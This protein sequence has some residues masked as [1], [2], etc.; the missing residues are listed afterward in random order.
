MIV[1][2]SVLTVLASLC[3]LAG[4]LSL[5]GAS[6]LALN[7]RA[8]VSSFPAPSAPTGV[9][10][11]QETGNVFVV[12]SAV[13]A[14]AA[15]GPEG[16]AP[17]GVPATTS[18]FITPTSEPIGVAVDNACWYHQPRLTGA[19][20]ETFDPSN[21]DLY[22]A[23]P[24]G[25]AIEKLSLNRLT[26]EY[27]VAGSFAFKEPNGVAVDH[28]GNV[29]VADY[30]ET[31]IPVFNTSG[32]EIGKIETQASA[33]PLI[34]HP[35]FI[36]AGS[37]GDV[38][39]S[40]YEGGTAQFT[41]NSKYEVQAERSLLPS[42]EA[43]TLDGSEDAL[44]DSGSSVAEYSSSGGLIGRFGETEPEALTES[45]GLAVNVTTGATFVSLRS[46]SI[47]N[48]YGATFKRPEP[49]TGPP[50]EL[51]PTSVTL[52]GTV[53]P[54]GMPVTSCLFEY[55]T[56]TSYEHTAP[57]ERSPGGEMT[58][59]VSAKITGLQPNTSYHYRAVASDKNGAIYGADEQFV[60]SGPPESLAESVSDVSVD[61]ATFKGIID[62]HKLPT[63]YYFQYGTSTGYGTDV[64]ALPGA[65]VG[66]GEDG[67]EV[68]QHVQGLEAGTVYHY[69]VVAHS[70]LG[71]VEGP[72]HTFTTQALESGSVVLD[73]REWELVSPPDKDGAL[74][75]SVTEET[76]IQASPDGQ[77]LT[78]VANS[79]TEPQPEGNAQLAQIFSTRGADGWS[80]R[81]ISIPNDEATGASVGGGGAY[82]FFSEDLGLALVS[83]FGSFPA[84]SSAASLSPEASAQTL[85]RRTDY[86]SK[87]VNST[88]LPASMHC[89]SPLVTGA[90]GFSDVPPGTVFS[91]LGATKEGGLN[92]LDASP[93]LDHVIFESSVPLT[94]TSPPASK[95]G[96][97]EWSAGKSRSEELQLV[98]VLSS[99]EPAI[100]PTLGSRASQRG[101][102]SDDG[103]RIIWGAQ[104]GFVPGL[105][106]RYTINGRGKTVQ[107]DDVQ[108]GPGDHQTAP[109]FQLAT[110]DGSKVFF[111]DTQ[112]LTSDSGGE[113]EDLY[114][115]EMVE[116]AGELTCKLTDLT[117]AGAGGES[118]AVQDAVIGSSTDGSS[119]YFVALGMLTGTEE[120]AHGERAQSEQPNLYVDRDGVIKLVAVLSAQ[121]RASWG[122]QVGGRLEKLTARVSPDGRWLAFMSQR[123]LT[124]Y[125]NHDVN[126]GKPDEEVYLYDAV[127]RQLVC[128]SCDPTG[129][130]PAGIESGQLSKG[131][132][133]RGAAPFEDSTWIAA[134][135]PGWTSYRLGD[136]LYQ[137]RYLSDSGRLFFNSDDALVPKDVDATEDV[138]EYEPAG[139]G[140]CNAASQTFEVGSDGCVG[141]ISSGESGEESAFLDASEDGGHV[142][143][144]T[145]SKLAGEDI[146]GALDVYDA[147]E[148]S[149]ASPCF[150]RPVALP[151]P[152]D[153]GDACKT[154][155][156]PQ[157]A[158]FGAPASSTFNG[159]GNLTSASPGRVVKGKALTRKQKLARALKV[160]VKQSKRKRA[161]CR[162][163]AKRVYGTVSNAK[164]T[165]KGGK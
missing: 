73:G 105:F 134:N 94:E 65:F 40:N 1:R 20:C 111:T 121:D 139:V 26:E 157:P 122:Y 135:V 61:S 35:A 140:D 80:T 19:A 22:V 125:D 95:G 33:H 25:N 100:N 36:A 131:G 8:F 47:V 110:P 13:G 6:A 130:R 159:A 96:L 74:L 75:E 4:G 66:S 3:V 30:F 147:H 165:H 90:E 162:R 151:P 114:E 143:F 34:A 9:A 118:A 108:G 89:Y 126:S 156:T 11:D 52:N 128:G 158:I 109:L 38:Y 45:R 88:C 71:T 37:F 43:V 39:V 107:L 86:L 51:R 104:P 12:E 32:A 150:A 62:P 14:I 142:F 63:T 27:E 153:T 78:Y 17:L 116:V 64:P 124:G 83:P 145:T 161:Q 99:N 102:I 113:G 2:R 21:G 67:V 155:P 164:K 141:L 148:C 149:P 42:G 137:S 129:A 87:E 44:V 24:I 132:L 84:P 57:C 97:Y 58:V 93:D 133:V 119:V 60:T 81:D 160:C 136:A 18:G 56:T 79:P 31:S 76:L 48:I 152:C 92:F 144:L 115:C 16:G 10:V 101:A 5:C 72:D 138:Y 53:N 54:E 112:R 28:D 146:D 55:G 29:Y 23:N 127:T 117:P 41:I 85:Y 98:S 103:S 82:R 7:G 49:I 59:P 15:F 123:S 69:R 154:S 70:S 68:S 50:T 77:A 163:R 91:G 120:N 106:M 46:S